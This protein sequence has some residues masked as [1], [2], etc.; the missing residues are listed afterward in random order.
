[1]FAGPPE[2]IV[3]G[4]LNHAG[5]KPVA[6]L[7]R[8]AGELAQAVHGARARHELAVADGERAEHQQALVVVGQGANQVGQELQGC[9]CS[10]RR[11][12]AIGAPAR[13]RRSMAARTRR[14]ARKGSR[15]GIA[16]A[17]RPPAW[18]TLSVPRW[19]SGRRIQH[20]AW[21]AMSREIAAAQEMLGPSW[22]SSW[23]VLPQVRPDSPA[24]RAVDLGESRF[25]ACVAPP[26][27]CP[28]RSRSLPAN[29]H[30]RS[31]GYVRAARLE[32]HRPDCV[33]DSGP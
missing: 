26:R 9:A 29:A 7:A 21:P 15:V 28:P 32:T 17:S 11:L 30:A 8:G 23:S 14:Y 27:D 12:A 13:R 6:R 25:H 5:E 2:G 10:S 3:P 20:V 1:M 31:R 33:E 4:N 18:L 24:P 22:L 16:M 19:T